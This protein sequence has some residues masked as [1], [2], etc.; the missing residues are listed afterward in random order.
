MFSADTYAHWSNLKLVQPPPP[1][2]KLR[3]VAGSDAVVILHPS[4]KPNVIVR[5]MTRVLLRMEWLDV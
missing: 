1:C 4:P 2:S 5:W 3:L